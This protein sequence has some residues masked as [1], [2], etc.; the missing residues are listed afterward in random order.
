MVEVEGFDDGGNEVSKIAFFEI[1]LFIVR[2]AS[3]IRIGCGG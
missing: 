2:F 3:G 1:F